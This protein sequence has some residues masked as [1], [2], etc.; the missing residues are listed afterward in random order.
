MIRVERM[1]HLSNRKEDIRPVGRHAIYLS[2]IRSTFKIS[3]EIAQSSRWKG[4]HSE[5]QA[6]CGLPCDK[7][8]NGTNSQV[9]RAEST[10][11]FLENM[12]LLK[13]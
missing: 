12:G 1:L 3:H 10:T 13:N 6:D 11:P 5:M 7:I 9:V 8:T 4:G 2:M